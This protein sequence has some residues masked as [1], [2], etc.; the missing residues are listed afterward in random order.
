ME[1]IIEI[2]I[3]IFFEV[4][5]EVI[6]EILVELG[7]GAIAETARAESETNR[8]LLT[9][10]YILL[11]L[12]FG[13][14]SVLLFPEPIIKNNVVKLFNFLLSPVLLG[15]SLCLISWLKRSRQAFDKR[16]FKLEKFINGCL[17]AVGYSAIRFIFT[18]YG[19]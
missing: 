1:V 18:H 15:F 6:F 16:F 12:I 11:G 3:Q 14:G 10:G 13:F 19:N 9:V 8:A 17:F 4:V 5:I 7:L 2:I